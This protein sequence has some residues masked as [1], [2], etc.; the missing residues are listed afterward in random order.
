MAVSKKV[1]IPGTFRL[2]VGNHSCVH[3]DPETSFGGGYES[4]SVEDYLVKGKMCVVEA[5]NGGDDFEI[6]CFI[7]AQNFFTGFPSYTGDKN[8]EGCKV[9]VEEKN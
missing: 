9:Y 4:G 7:V 5:P 1:R 3:E 2:E 6:E 8:A